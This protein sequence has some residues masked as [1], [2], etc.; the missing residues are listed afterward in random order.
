MFAIALWDARERRLLLARDPFG[1]KPLYWTVAGGVL[2]FASELKALRAPPGF[3]AE[4]D[5]EALDAYLA[6]N[7]V[8]APLSIYRG[9]HKLEAGHLLEARDGRRARCAGSR[10]RPRCPRPTCGARAGGTL[11]AELR[12][13]LRDS[14]RAH[15]EADVPVGV[16]LSGGDRLVAAGGARRAEASPGAVADVLD[17]LRGA[18]V[19][20]ARRGR[21]WSRRATGPTTTSS[22]CGPT[23]PR[24][25]RRS[26]P[27][28]T[29]R[30]R[31]PR[32][33]RPTPSRASR[34]ATSR[35]R[36]RA[37]AATSCSAATSPTS[38]T[39]SPRDRGWRAGAS[40]LRP[41]VERL[42]SLVAAR[43]ARLQGQ[44]LR[45]RGGAAA[46]GAPPRL[47]GDLL[48][49][50]PGGAARAGA[51]GGRLRPAR[52]AGGPAT[53]RPRAPSRSPACRTSTS[54]PTSP[55]TSS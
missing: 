25:C 17:R 9:V 51:P 3:A 52:R 18:V 2:V 6:F 53:P 13:R 54:G 21:G 50:R 16:F 20:R 45:P 14:V 11:A 40:A 48:G 1:I 29:S 27:R 42:P 10:G 7:S 24:C 46:A 39:S 47:E 22:S 23:P 28:S 34:R 4:V 19:R 41:L 26:P 36:S 32:R 12:S 8:P 37:R 35:S 33:C 5:L 31:T 49:R 55:T 44:A 15:L 43:L 30:S 38:P